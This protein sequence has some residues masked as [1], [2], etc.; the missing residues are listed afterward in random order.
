MTR[1]TTRRAVRRYAAALGLFALLTGMTGVAG[2]VGA[3][4]GAHA[5]RHVVA[6]NSTGSD[7]EKCKSPS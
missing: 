7:C 1:R 6:W 2:R 5:D 4:G 3:D